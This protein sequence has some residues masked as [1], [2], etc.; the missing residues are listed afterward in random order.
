M[1]RLFSTHAI[2]RSSLLSFAMCVLSSFVHAQ[3][4]Q[5]ERDATLRDG[6]R[7]YLERRATHYATGNDLMRYG[8]GG[9]GNTAGEFTMQMLTQKPAL[10]D[11]ESLMVI[12][13]G[14]WE[15]WFKNILKRT[16]PSGTFPAHIWYAKLFDWHGLA[17]SQIKFVR[18]RDQIPR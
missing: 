12:R 3:T 1:K 8:P 18:H 9:L 15:M 5:E 14:R 4:S 7:V 13:P 2:Y 10:T 6:F 16:L 11:I 17:K